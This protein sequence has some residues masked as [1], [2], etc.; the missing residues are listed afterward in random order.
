M[1]KE[2]ISSEKSVYTTKGDHNPIVD[3][4]TVNTE[5]IY[6]KILFKIPKIGYVQDFFSKPTNYFTC[7]LGI[8]LLAIIYQGSY[9]LLLLFKGKKEF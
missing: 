2:S 9:I 7:L 8:A 6:G 5:S 1:N 4:S 3:S